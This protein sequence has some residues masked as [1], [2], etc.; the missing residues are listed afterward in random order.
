MPRVTYNTIIQISDEADVD[1]IIRYAGISSFRKSKHSPFIFADC[2]HP[3]ILS[4]C[5][6]VESVN[7]EKKYSPLLVHSL[8]L[9]NTYKAK[10]K[11]FTGAGVNVA[12]IDTGCDTTDDIF[13]RDAPGGGRECI[14][15][16]KVSVGAIAG[17]LS[18][19]SVDETGHGT[20]VCGIV[21]GV[22]PGCNIYSLDVK[23]ME[24]GVSTAYTSDFDVLYSWIC[25]HPELNIEV[26]N[27]SWGVDPA[28]EHQ[29]VY[30]GD[31]LSG[32]VN[33]YFDTYG[34]HTIV[35]SGNDGFRQGVG[36]PACAT[37]A[38]AVG[39]TYSAYW[40]A[41]GLDKAADT[42]EPVNSVQIST[43]PMQIT[44][45]SNTGGLVQLLAPGAVITAG[46]V[47]ASGTSM[48]A[49]HV[50]GAIAVLKGKN[51]TL[52]ILDC[53][54]ILKNTGTPVTLETPVTV[55]TIPHID[56]D[57]ATA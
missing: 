2:V 46:G 33:W 34:I 29:T 45:F 31:A 12:V 16:G 15:A 13:W 8:A 24:A 44:R 4:D 50:V 41:L 25:D 26:V 54:D 53:V 28:V 43:R 5:P 39:A 21:A 14:V 52:S 27:L 11:G 7:T 22:A 17:D 49:P 20:L 32:I 40:G 18:Y 30:N 37:R 57:E 38:I 10:I 1:A 23:F 56:L 47:T 42:A 9:T 3:E 48:A 55:Y 19:E 36:A 51:P 35:A 6:G